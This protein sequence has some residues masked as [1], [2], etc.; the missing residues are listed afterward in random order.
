[1][2]KIHKVCYYVLLTLISVLFLFS[3]YTK[4]SGNAM[5]I[6]GFQMA[7][8]PVWFMYFIGVCEIL[9]AIGLWFG[10]KCRKLQAWAAYGLLIIL[11]GAIV[12]TAMFV[13]AS[14]ALFPVIAAIVLGLVL[15]LGKKRSATIST[16][17][18]PTQIS[19]PRI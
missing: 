1:M 3:G 11:A 14:E 4:V 12:T 10:G 6:A 8:L 5:A 16:A 17:A 19:T 13:S 15:W 18:A 2:T 7:H 9:G